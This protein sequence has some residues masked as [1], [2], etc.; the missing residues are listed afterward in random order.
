MFGFNK[1]SLE[2]QPLL[3]FCSSNC[4]NLLS[5]ISKKIFSLCL[6]QKSVS[7]NGVTSSFEFAHSAV[8]QALMDNKSQT[9][10][11]HDFI[12]KLVKLT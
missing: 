7:L 3:G 10:H 9:L 12:S 2:K 6:I 1:S 8:I 5:W 11:W 4:S